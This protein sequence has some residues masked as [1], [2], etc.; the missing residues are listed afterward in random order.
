MARSSRSRRRLGLLRTLN[1]MAFM[2]LA[3]RAPT[4]GRLLVALVRDERVPTSRKA[5]LG[6]AVAYLALPIDLIP[7][8]IPVIGALDDLAVVV[9]ALDIFLE[10]VPRELLDQ[11]LVELDIDPNELERDLAQ[12]RRFVPGPVRRA[13]A[14]LPDLLDGAASLAAKSGVQERFREWVNS[15]EMRARRARRVDGKAPAA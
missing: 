7:E 6:L 11:K 1:Y 3:S 13:F 5:V 9:L 10:S 8:T 14:R 15:D 2:P 12:V 4:Y